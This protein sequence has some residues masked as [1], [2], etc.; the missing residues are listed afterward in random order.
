MKTCIFAG[1]FDPITNG[2]K[3]VIEK[4][5]EMFDKVIVAIGEN[6]DK[7]PYFSLEE[8]AQMI[9]GAF[10]ENE[11]VVVDTFSGMLVDYMKKNNLTINVR[12]IR[13]QRDYEYETT[14]AKFN[15]DMYED[16][17][18]LYFP[19]PSELAHV[20]SSVVKNIL[21]LDGDLSKYVPQSVVDVIKKRQK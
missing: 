12:G 20:S 6:K 1:S 16:I 18:T 10:N 5:L 14:M 2:H 21:S 9:K 4:C 3:Y 19:T 13:D 15:K 17:I 7:H 11:R 8:R